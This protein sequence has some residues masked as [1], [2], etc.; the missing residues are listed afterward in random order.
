[1]SVRHLIVLVLLWL[2]VGLELLACLGLMAMRN[3]FD[4]LHFGSP[5]ALGLVLIA[6]SVLVDK[7]FSMIGDKA[8][9][10]AAMVLVGSP[11]ATHAI[12][13]TARILERG[14]WRLGEEEDVEVEVP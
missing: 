3:V 14:D 4:R 11:L 8:L 13:R 1:M 6:L 9:L 12:G 5:A 10:I 7:D 2:G